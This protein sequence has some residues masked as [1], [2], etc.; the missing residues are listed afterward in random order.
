MR[1]KCT[2][3]WVGEGGMAKFE[4]ESNYHYHCQLCAV[5]VNIKINLY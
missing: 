4:I 2:K 3:E 5:A 1:K